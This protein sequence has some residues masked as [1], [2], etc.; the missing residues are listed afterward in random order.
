MRFPA[1]L[2]AP[3]LIAGADFLLPASLDRLAAIG[4]HHQ[5]L[6]FRVI[7]LTFNEGILIS[8]LVVLDGLINTRKVQNALRQ[9]HLS[10]L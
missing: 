1:Q 2:F 10:L 8:V 7:V 4:H 5:A 3:E 9:S 6:S